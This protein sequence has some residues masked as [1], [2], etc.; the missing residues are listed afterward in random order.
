MNHGQKFRGEQKSWS[1]SI[2]TECPLSKLCY[3]QNCQLLKALRETKMFLC[4]LE[5]QENVIISSDT[6]VYFVIN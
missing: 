3:W 5:N 2:H 4:Q 6:Q 1:H